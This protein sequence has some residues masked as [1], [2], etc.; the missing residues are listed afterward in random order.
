MLCIVCRWFLCVVFTAPNKPSA[1]Q[2]PPAPSG[3]RQ[4]DMKTMYKYVVSKL[5]PYWTTVGDYLEYSVVERNSFRG[6]NNKKSLA[7][8]LENWISTDNGRK[9][10]T[11]STFIRVLEELDQD[12]SIS[13]GNQICASLESEVFSPSGTLSCVVAST[14]IGH[15]ITCY[16]FIHT[17]HDKSV[18]Y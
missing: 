17:H 13:V 15:S 12:L 9:P 5:S 18:E 16:L 4:L 6:A 14:L 8:L 7:T 2:S 3:E 1:G 10:K 11:W